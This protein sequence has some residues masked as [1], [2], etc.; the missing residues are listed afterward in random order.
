V[1]DLVLFDEG[2]S[3]VSSQLLHHTALTTSGHL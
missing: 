3:R 2:N 1:R